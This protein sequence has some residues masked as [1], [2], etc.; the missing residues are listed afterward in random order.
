MR[1]LG[2]FVLISI[3]LFGCEKVQEAEVKSF[4]FNDEE[5][6]FL[7]SDEEED[8]YTH[9]GHI[10]EVSYTSE[11]II[12]TEIDEDIYII[13]GDLNGYQITKNGSL[14][15]VCDEL[16]A[17]SGYETVSFQEDIVEIIKL[18]IKE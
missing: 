10:I 6:V 17:C 4:Y 16:G 18:Y 3:F 5:Y 1:K 11:V 13:M 2:L 8:H 9:N 15:S 12:S 14:L 7:R